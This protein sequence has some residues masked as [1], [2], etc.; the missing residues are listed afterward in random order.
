M[1]NEDRIVYAKWEADP[2]QEQPDE[3]MNT[4]TIYLTNEQLA[5]RTERIKNIIAALKTIMIKRVR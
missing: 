1:P 4:D 3:L 5:K 2:L